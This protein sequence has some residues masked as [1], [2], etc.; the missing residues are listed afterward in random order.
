[1]IYKQSLTPQQAL[2]KLKHFCGYLERSH[3]ETQQ[4]LYSFGLYKK[5]V[6][7]LLSQLIEENYLNEER[8]AIAF[9]GGR[10]RIKQWG[11]IKIKYELQQHKVSSYNITK[12]LKCID[13]LDYLNTLNSL[14][15]K[16]WAILKGEQYLTKQAKANSYLLQKG[17]EQP[18]I[19]TAIS[20]LKKQ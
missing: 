1:M 18:L 13:D 10:F 20:N 5:D 17:F 16:K 15:A 8:Y 9:A 14:A 19:S 4:K 6:D 11:K 2:Q 12:A 3:Y 7:M